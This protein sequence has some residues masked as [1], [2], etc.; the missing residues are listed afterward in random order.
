MF[1][2]GGMGK[3]QAISH[4]LPSVVTENPGE[5]LTPAVFGKL[6]DAFFPRVYNY[7]AY[8]VT[9]REE[10]EDL[11]ALVFEKV[12]SHYV[13]FDP[14]RGSFE[15]WIFGIA[16]NALSNQRR[17]DARRPQAELDEAIED[18]RQPAPAE[19]V[20]QQEELARLKLYLNRLNERDREL[21]ALRYGASLS[22]RKTAE[23]LNMTETNVGVALSRA[24][25]RLRHFFESDEK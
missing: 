2:A 24:L 18:D 23:L 1:R 19:L 21:L 9:S 3:Q 7:F 25:R 15:N 14:A 4:N 6:Y 11:T 17:T 16:R 8:R 22:Q 13:Q 10:A 20:L 5:R 12:I